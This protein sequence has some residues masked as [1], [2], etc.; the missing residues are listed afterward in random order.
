[1]PRDSSSLIQPRTG[2]IL[3]ASSPV[4]RMTEFGLYAQDYLDYLHG[5]LFSAALFSFL[6]LGKPCLEAIGSLNIRSIDTVERSRGQCYSPVQRRL[7][8]IMN[9]ESDLA[10]CLQFTPDFGHLATQVSLQN[11]YRETFL[12]HHIYYTTY[13]M[14]GSDFLHLFE[15][16][17]SCPPLRHPFQIDSRL[18]S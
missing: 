13:N 18:K 12:V 16:S 8:I 9:D 7:L 10:G 4:V 17:R 11:N 15:A 5:Q 2:A 1:M 6:F 14:L 3:L